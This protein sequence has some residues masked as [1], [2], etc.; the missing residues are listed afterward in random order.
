VSKWIGMPTRTA[1]STSSGRKSRPLSLARKRSAGVTL[2]E[3]AIVLP[4]FISTLFAL[5][6]FSVAFNA[7]L[8]IN[9]AS[10]AGA[11]IAGQAGNN[12]DAD[13][14]ILSRIDQ[15][16]SAPI[17]K[18]SVQQVKIFRASS[19]GS[20]I[21]ASSTYTRSGSTDCGTYSV[22]YSATSS[23]Y[24]PAQR[25]NILAG[26]P[27]MSPARTTVDKIGVQITY[28]YN[29]VTP[30]RSVLTFIGGSGSGYSWTF[31]KQ[32]ESRMEPVL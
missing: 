12:P 28:Q 10:Q 27:T 1:P 6:E 18:S 24:P 16:L 13:C 3:F 31:A 20:T 5:I 17:D 4:I 19:T 2:V 21:L 30:L 22:P 32:N 9:R 8:T 15:E 29:G 25:C 7:V 14:V 11:L 26:C 23:G